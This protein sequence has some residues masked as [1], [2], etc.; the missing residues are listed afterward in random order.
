MSPRIS[1]PEIDKMYDTAIKAGAL[2]GKVT[3]AG[4]GGYMLIYCEYDKRHRVA[5]ALDHMGAP[6]T[7]VGFD[8]E[9]LRRWTTQVPDERLEPAELRAEFRR[10]IDD[11]LTAMESVHNGLALEHPPGPPTR[12]STRCALTAS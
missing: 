9:G 10:R 6:V 4:G 8:H 1:T 12:S 3:G 7:D 5:A 11:H 2:G